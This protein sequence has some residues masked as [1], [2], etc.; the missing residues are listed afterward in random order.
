MKRTCMVLMAVL[1]VTLCA[2]DAVRQ[3]R[4]DCN[5][6]L[7][8]T[9]AANPVSAQVAKPRFEDNS[10]IVFGARNRIL[11]PQCKMLQSASGTLEMRIKSINWNGSD[12][13]YK[14]FFYARKGNGA[15]VVFLR[16]NEEGKIEFS[17]GKLPHDLAT[18][19]ADASFWEP[20][21]YHT[22][23]IIW[24]KEKMAM[25]VDGRQA[26]ERKRHFQ[27]LQWSDPLWI[28]GS[29]WGTSFGDS[30][31]DYFRLAPKAE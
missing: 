20:N 15:D 7:N 3:I 11:L 28:G 2:D 25:F 12:N 9:G 5:G 29:I 1:A 8:I 22:L 19:T 14:Y 13:T 16:K 30:A 23:K 27:E 6:D 18:L 4:M 21:Q 10:A 31:L 26:A 17:I 24:D